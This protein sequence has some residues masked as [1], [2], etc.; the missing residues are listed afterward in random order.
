[1]KTLSIKLLILFLIVASVVTLFLEE[2]NLVQASD[3]PSIEGTYILVSRVLPDG[4]I[5]KPPD[6]TGL[7]TFTGEYRNFNVHW[8]GP[9]GEDFS[10]S[11]I[12]KYSL[13]ATEY[14]ETCVYR[15]ANDE[16]EG[17]GLAYDFSGMSGTAPVTVKEDGS[18]SMKL[19][20]FEEPNVVFKGD[21]F[22]ASVEG[23]F[24]D[25]WEKVK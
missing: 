6:V 4:S 10:I 14:S 22:V 13:S 25:Y 20:L 24:K 9:K 5:V 23:V 19:P 3:V 7:I 18:I 8:K 15:L 16:I 2:K 12:S 1:M 21:K 11:S 17:T